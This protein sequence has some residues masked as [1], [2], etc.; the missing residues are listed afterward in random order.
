MVSKAGGFENT[1]EKA[2]G[3]QSKPVRFSLK[4]RSLQGFCLK[5]SKTC[6]TANRV[7]EQV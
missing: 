2:L 5:N 6:S 3:L 1:L 4:K 7:V